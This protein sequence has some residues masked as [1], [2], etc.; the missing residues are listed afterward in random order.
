MENRS[1]VK[2]HVTHKD[3][4]LP[5]VGY[6][7]DLLELTSDDGEKV[8]DSDGNIEPFYMDLNNFIYADVFVRDPDDNIVIEADGQ[9]PLIHPETII[10]IEV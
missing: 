3:T 6:S 5:A 10:H 1:L 7:I 9:Y 4:G 8:T 2:I